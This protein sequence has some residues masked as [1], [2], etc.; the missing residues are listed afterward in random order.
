M[1]RRSI[2]SLSWPFEASEMAAI[3]E[4][5]LP[6]AQA[7]VNTRRVIQLEADAG[8]VWPTARLPRCRLPRSTS[9]LITSRPA[10]RRPF[11]PPPATFEAECQ[12]V[13]HMQASHVGFVGSAET[14]PQP[15]AWSLNGSTPSRPTHIAPTQIV[16]PSGAENPL[17]AG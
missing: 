7:A 14:E 4:G 2:R 5:S 8:R 6:S 16:G 1:W 13:V 11:R 3:D 12:H 17:V 10:Y 15:H 9:E